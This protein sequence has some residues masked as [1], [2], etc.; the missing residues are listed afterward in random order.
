MLFTVIVT[1]NT[2]IVCV[3]KRRLRNVPNS[4][5][6]QGA[7]ITKK[8]QI[9]ANYCLGN[10]MLFTVIVT[11]N[12]NIVCVKKRRVMYRHNLKTVLNGALPVPAATLKRQ[13]VNPHNRQTRLIL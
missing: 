9:T 2:N 7:C 8:N 12:T 6:K 10:Q 1:R 5:K 3:K 11:R 13:Q 4:Q